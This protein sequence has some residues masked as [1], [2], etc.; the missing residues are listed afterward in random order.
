MTRR[1]P[2]LRTSVRGLLAAHPAV[3]FVLGVLF[4]GQ[5]PGEPLHSRMFLAVLVVF[6][7]VA[8]IAYECTRRGGTLDLLDQLAAGDE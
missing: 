1:T 3:W 4:A 7:V 8:G 2:G 5:L 6:A